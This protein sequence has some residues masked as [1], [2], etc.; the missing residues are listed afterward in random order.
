ML[1]FS[2]LHFLKKIIDLIIYGHFWIAGAAMTMCLQTQY[3]L[4]GR[5]S[6]SPLVCFVFFG[7]L[8]LYALHRIVGLARVKP[9]QG[10][11]RFFI[12][13]RFKNH[14]LWYAMLSGLAAFWFYL[15][16]NRS[17]QIQL[18]WPCLLSAGYVAPILFGKRRLRDLNYLKIFLIAFVWAWLTVFLPAKEIHLDFNL[19]VYFMCA[20]RFFFIF[21]ITLP[22]DIR[23]LKIDLHTQVKTIPSRIG[24]RATQRLSAVLLLGT[25]A[26]AGLNWRLNAYDNAVLFLLSLSVLISFLLI[27]F[28]PKAKNDYYFSGLLDGMMIL[29]FA[30]VLLA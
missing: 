6:F 23:D 1:L 14:I 25:I 7:A 18:L 20:E 28:S 19:A 13:A 10:S 8:F 24:I 2:A 22:F 29:Q 26:F 15:Q 9:F 12:I 27:Y 3:L 17:I 30:L 21:A 11:G 4:S 16:L 5:F